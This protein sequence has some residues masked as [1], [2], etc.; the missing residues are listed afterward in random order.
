MEINVSVYAPA[1]GFIWE[2]VK[3]YG[4]DTEALFA[5]AGVDPKL[6]LDPS[7]RVSE[8]QVDELI[9]CAKKESRDEDFIFHVVNQLHPSYL[10]ALGYA[11]LNSGSLRKSFQRIEKFGQSVSDSVNI[12]LKNVADDLQVTVD[13]EFS[14]SRDP[15]LR[16]LHH[17]ITLVR[18][19]RMIYGDSFAPG[20]V[21]FQQSEPANI[22]SCYEFIRCEL[23]FDAESTI[24]IIPALIA[25]EPLPGFNAQFVHQFDQMTIDYLA[26]QERLDIVGRTKAEILKQLPSGETS[27]ES[28]AATLNLSTR[29]LT[30]KLKEEGQSFKNLLAITRRE[31]SEKY[32]RNRSLSLTEISFLLGFSETSS[33]SRAY[34]SWTGASPT[35]FRE[36]LS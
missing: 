15:A 4:L 9:Y 32:I 33:F 2:S 35:E 29:T 8:K 21:H 19:C 36:A 28:V 31:L 30:R 27:L 14:E 7:A 25:D 16:E 22:N 20:S 24:L 6:R 34:K 13:S 26:A 17:V 1:L 3:K 5:Q 11:W 10:G 23:F 12:H 18:M